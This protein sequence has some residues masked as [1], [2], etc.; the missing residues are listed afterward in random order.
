M[1]GLAK[2]LP[3]LDARLS[4]VSSGFA[5]GSALVE[6]PALLMS[7]PA[8]GS[9]AIPVPMGG[10]PLPQNESFRSLIG[11]EQERVIENLAD[12]R[13]AVASAFGERGCPTA[14][15]MIETYAGALKGEGRRP[16]PDQKA[17]KSLL[18]D[19]VIGSLV[20]LVSA[21]RMSG[22]PVPVTQ[23]MITLAEAVLG[24]DVATAGR[25][26]ETIGIEAT[27]TESARQAMDAI[28]GGR[29]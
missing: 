24:A 13:A 15:E 16:I 29:R 8:L 17:A 12:E 22:V 7:G 26:L 11:P 20:P 19:G 25:K 21:A 5:D 3:N 9:G 14:G 27:T 23:S 18:R 10:K 1:E 6:F 28:A 2:I 4:V